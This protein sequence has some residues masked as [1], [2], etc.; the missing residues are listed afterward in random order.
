[1]SWHSR[2]DYFVSV[3]PEGGSHA[4]VIHQV[5][6]QRSQL[7]FS[8]SKGLVQAVVFHPTRPFLFVAV[9]ILCLMLRDLSSPSLSYNK[10]FNN[11]SIGMLHFK[12][13]SGLGV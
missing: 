8:K 7:P 12:C 9:S 2:G 10:P 6:K 3:A 5:S 11:L 4:V 1:M 13:S